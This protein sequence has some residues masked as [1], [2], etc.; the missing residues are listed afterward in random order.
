MKSREPTPTNPT[1]RDYYANQPEPWDGTCT[2]CGH[3][4]FECRGNCTCL[5]CNAQRQNEISKG[6]LFEDD[7]P[8]ERSNAETVSL[9]PID[10]GFD[11]KAT[12]HLVRLSGLDVTYEDGAGRRAHVCGCIETVA[13]TLAQA[14]YHVVAAQTPAGRNIQCTPTADAPAGDGF[15][16]SSFTWAVQ[17]RRDNYWCRGA[18]IL[19]AIE[20]AGFRPDEIKPL[21]GSHADGKEGR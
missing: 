5:A 7:P 20:R 8:W 14:G 6:L 10:V 13:E 15:C 18:S 16:G 1:R 12:K 9:L 17:A 3:S 21:A 4:Y 2:R 11:L 19:A